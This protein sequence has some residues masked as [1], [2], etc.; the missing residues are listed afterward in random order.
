VFVCSGL[1][2]IEQNKGTMLP[3]HTLVCSG[4]GEG[5]QGCGMSFIVAAE[6]TILLFSNP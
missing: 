3:K 6:R 4:K 5:K 2:I 1:L